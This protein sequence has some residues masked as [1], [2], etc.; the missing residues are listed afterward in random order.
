M[1]GS[2]GCDKDWLSGPRLPMSVAVAVVFL[3]LQSLCRK[4]CVRFLR[5][6]SADEFNARRHREKNGA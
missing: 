3:L 2:R 1:V 5:Q 4:E 6:I